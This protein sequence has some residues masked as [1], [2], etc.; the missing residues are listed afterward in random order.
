LHL[1]IYA[2]EDDMIAVDSSVGKIVKFLQTISLKSIFVDDFRL[3]FWSTVTG[4]DPNKSLYDQKLMLQHYLYDLYDRIEEKPFRTFAKS[5][6]PELFANCHLSYFWC[7]PSL[8]RLVE[9]GGREVSASKIATVVRKSFFS[10]IDR[11]LE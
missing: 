5:S 9:V 3:H 7:I 11:K 6:T 1:G 10:R 2:F 8:Y 4:L